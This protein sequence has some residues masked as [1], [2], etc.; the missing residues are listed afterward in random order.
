[1]YVRAYSFYWLYF[2]AVSFAM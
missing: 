2:V 1:M